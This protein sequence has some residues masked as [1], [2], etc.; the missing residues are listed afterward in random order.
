[1]KATLDQCTFIKNWEV[2]ASLK[3]IFSLTQYPPQF[4][5]YF[6]PFRL[7]KRSGQLEQKV[8]FLLCVLFFVSFFTLNSK[9]TIYFIETSVTMTSVHSICLTLKISFR[10]RSTICL[11]YWSKSRL[12]CYTV[13]KSSKTWIVHIAENTVLVYL[14]GSYFYISGGEHQSK[15][16]FGWKWVAL[17][18]MSVKL[19]VKSCKVMTSNKL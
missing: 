3:I 15:W 13:I 4:H 6:F 18:K 19:T 5:W 17:L 16:H 2:K 7:W 11:R 8:C 12:S 1:M 9:I 10:T 14:S